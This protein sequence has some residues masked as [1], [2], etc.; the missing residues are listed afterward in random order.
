MYRYINNNAS[1][2]TIPG[3]A[4]SDITFTPGQFS[5]NDWYSRFL[6]AGQL[7]REVVVP[8]PSPTPARTTAEKMADFFNNTDMT[9]A[10]A[11]LLQE[12][13]TAFE[14]ASAGTVL[15]KE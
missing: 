14:A 15:V 9:D 4:G 10:E 3:P 6:G 8:L 2:I 1:A 11:Q 5:F 12:F 13:L 7:T